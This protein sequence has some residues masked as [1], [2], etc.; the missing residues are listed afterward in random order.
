MKYYY[1]LTTLF[2]YLKVSTILYHYGDSY[3]ALIQTPSN[4]KK[5]DIE[6]FRLRIIQLEVSIL[7]I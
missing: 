6:Q 5:F 7:S 1:T 2:N 4:S 3:Q